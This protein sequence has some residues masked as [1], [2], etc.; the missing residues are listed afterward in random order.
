MGKWVQW[1]PLVTEGYRSVLPLA[2][3]PQ[4]L[5]VF[6]LSSKLLSAGLTH[7]IMT[8]RLFPP[9]ESC[10]GGVLKGSEQLRA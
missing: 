6:R 8:V 2:T 10:E 4:Y 7:A 5:S 3:A 9:N 1:S